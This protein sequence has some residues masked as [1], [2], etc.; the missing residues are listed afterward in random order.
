MSIVDRIY[1]IIDW[2][3]ISVNEFSKRI[4]V[5]NGYFA[6]QR[7][8][9]ANVGSQVIEKVVRECP[10]VNLYWLITGEGEMLKPDTTL[11]LKSSATHPSSV[12]NF[13]R[14][15]NIYN[16]YNGLIKEKDAIIEKKDAEIN[17][18]H[19]RIGELQEKLRTN[20][21]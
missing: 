7:S 16:V 19:E 12:D 20:I 4:D 17:R 5:S 18:L 8:A 6:K 21:A 2:K 10:E 11:S 13:S 9:N 15:C 1:K 14:V 3:D